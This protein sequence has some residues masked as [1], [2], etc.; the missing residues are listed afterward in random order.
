MTGSSFGSRWFVGVAT[1]A[2]LAFG[3]A[4][5]AQAQE[6][7]WYIG[8]NMPLMFID[9][10]DATSTTTVGP[11]PQFLPQPV[12]IDATVTTEHDTGFKFGATLGYHI[13]SSI[14]IEGEL[15]LARADIAQITNTNIIVPGVTL[16]EFEVPLHP[17]GKG[18]QFGAMLNIWY[19]IETGSDWTPYVG[20]GLGL[21]RID[22]SDLYYDQ[23]QLA[24]EVLDRLPVP[25]ALANQLEVPELSDTDTA[26]AYQFGAGI[27]Y[28]LSETAT[29]QI[30]YRLQALNGLEFTG[31]NQIA[32]VR[33]E[34]DLRMHFLEIGIRQLF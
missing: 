32:S 23:G 18:E 15:F 21:I 34:T 8:A 29:L 7:S 28:A 27:G 26:F 17:N 22:Q 12:S 1:A 16:G 13:D 25:P 31:T 2:C 6:G 24:R 14:R 3:G 4:S 10:S 9:D 33:A 5:A 11:I 30:G 19:D 20:A